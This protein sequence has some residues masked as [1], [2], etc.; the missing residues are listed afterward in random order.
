MKTYEVIYLS[1]EEKKVKQI[2]A[3]RYKI[4]NYDTAFFYV[5]KQEVAWFDTVI[6]VW[7]VQ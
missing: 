5:G 3:D 4:K 2:Q 1:G 7:E 6:A